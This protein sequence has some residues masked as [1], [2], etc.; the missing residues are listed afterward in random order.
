MKK[1]KWELHLRINKIW[2]QRLQLISSYFT[3]FHRNKLL[4]MVKWGLKGLWIAPGYKK[5]LKCWLSTKAHQGLHHKSFPQNNLTSFKRIHRYSPSPWNLFVSWFSFAFFSFL[6]SLFNRF[7]VFK[8]NVRVW[9]FL[10]GK[11]SFDFYFCILLL[12][13]KKFSSD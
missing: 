10:W 4:L 11:F 7:S 3:V 8:Q 13:G 5:G 2:S 12:F 9:N 6:F 1:K